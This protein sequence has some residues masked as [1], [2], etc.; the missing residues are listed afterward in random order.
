MGFKGN[1]GYFIIAGII[2]VI[3]IIA[4]IS[5]NS[6]GTRKTAASGKVVITIRA[7]IGVDNITIANLNTG[8]SIIKTSLNL[9]Y[10]FNVTKSDSIQ[11]IVRTADGYMFNAWEFGDGTFNNHNPF[12]LEKVEKDTTMTATVLMTNQQNLLGE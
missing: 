6:G 11:A 5:A 2:L 7:G 8:T 4:I 9:P 12:I 1:R 10:S 3:L